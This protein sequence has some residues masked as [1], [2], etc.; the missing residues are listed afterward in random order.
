MC[1]FFFNIFLSKTYIYI[2]RDKQ[3]LLD[4]DQESMS[5]DLSMLVLVPTFSWLIWAASSSCSE[6]WPHPSSFFPRL[7]PLPSTSRPIYKAGDPGG[8]TYIS[9]SNTQTWTEMIICFFLS[10]TLRCSRVAWSCFLGQRV[11][12]SLLEDVLGDPEV[13]RTIGQVGVMC[14][15]KRPRHGTST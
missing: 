8:Q 5:L 3:F 2:L 11:L 9:A 7:L 6:S 1:F 4:T 12:N 15:W 10:N 13:E 14:L